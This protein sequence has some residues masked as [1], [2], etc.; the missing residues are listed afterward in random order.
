MKR[1]IQ[2]SVFLFA[3]VTTVG[4]F[5]SFNQASSDDGS[6]KVYLENKCSSDIRVYIT[7][8]GGG[9]THTINHNSTKTME[10]SAGEK[11]YTDGDRKLIAEV[12]TSSE[13]K[14]IVICQ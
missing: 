13:G 4:I 8:T 10:I 6:V 1:I 7:Q 3:A 5:S 11:I 12:T 14:T 2:V 9:A